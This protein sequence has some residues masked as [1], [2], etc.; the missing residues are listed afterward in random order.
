YLCALPMEA[1]RDAPGDR[2]AAA[3]LA[4]LFGAP[5]AAAMAALI[6]VSTFG[7]NNGLI[8]SGAR[9]YYAMAQDGLFFRRA[10]SLNRDSVPGVALV[11]QAAWACGLCLTG[12]YGDLLDYVIFATLIFYCLTIAG[13][14]VL[15]RRRPQAARPHRAW[16]YPVLPALYIAV[17]AAIGADLLVY[18]P[19]YTWPGL[20]IVL[21]GIPAYYLRRRSA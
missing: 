14:F 18:K 15:R 19:A 7:C 1:L 6:M 11:V 21:L 3:A 13:V 2:V 10:A 16:G 5:G 17:S 8:L 20:L 4:G 12:A 9:V